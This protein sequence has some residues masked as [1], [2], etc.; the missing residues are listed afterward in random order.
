MSEENTQEVSRMS[1]TVSFHSSSP[2][3]KLSDKSE[4]NNSSEG[5]E[6]NNDEKNLNS[7]NLLDM[8][9]EE[10]Q[11]ESQ[12]MEKNKDNEKSTAVNNSET[13][14]CDI[15]ADEQSNSSLQVTPQSQLPP[16][17]NEE[18]QSSVATAVSEEQGIDLG[19]CYCGRERNLNTVEL[20]CAG[21][22]KWFH[23]SCIT[24][25]LGKCVPFMTNYTFLCKN[26]NVT[27]M[28]N[29]TKK[30]S[31]FSQMCA[32]A[33]A[34]LLQQNSPKTTFSKDKDIIPFIEKHW[35]H[36]TTMP[37]RIKQT[38]HT[39]VFKTMLKDSEIFL[40]EEKNPDDYSDDY[41][42]FGL[43]VNDLSKIGP[44]YE[45]LI[46]AGQVKQ[47][48]QD[49]AFNQSVG[50]ISGKGRS[51]KRKFPG[52]GQSASTGKKPRSDLTMPKLPPH[53]YPLEHPFNKDGY[54]YILAEPDPHAPFRQEF[55]ESPDW[56]G[57]PIPG[58]LYRKLTPNFVLWALHDRAPQLKIGED[59]I[60]VTGEK[61]YCMIRSTHGIHSGTWY[62][63]CT[64]EDMPDGSA[65]RLGWSQALG[66][67]QAPLGYDR[68][69]Y[70]WRSRKGTRFHQSMG[71]HYSNGGYGQG[72]TLGFLI[73]LPSIDDTV[74]L[75]QTYKDKPLVKFK[76]YL[77]FEDKDD[78]QSAIKGLKPLPG[79]KITFYKNGVNM[80]IAWQDISAG[81]YYPA[82]SLYK[83]CTVSANFG[84][85]FRYPPK[86][87]KF[88]AICE[89]AQ[90]AIIEQTLSDM[91]YLIEN[92]GKLR[93]DTF[94]M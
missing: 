53:G 15:I 54:R 82:L 21:C 44:N 50:F 89:A 31:N 87:T 92:E 17:I 4:K 73:H 88:R 39:T 78:I 29:F 30:Q 58:W 13:S 64:I 16:L 27:G 41:P 94:M 8:Y 61:G 28:E 52:D 80:G 49:F 45:S 11:Q 5:T 32:T 35:E 48:M 74:V 20:Q 33:I 72:D 75:P 91:L 12:N 85:R 22:L 77:Y 26:C 23:D 57:K 60:Y 56:A 84:P 66:N 93:L 46:R 62:F 83:S 90:D 79:S 10:S 70:S 76:S 67:L 1:E 69:S 19:N 2:T 71:Y 9:L 55:D 65:T 7:S 59:R 3:V 24:F 68:F 86:D 43:V 14:S 42:H 63:E 37:R 36:L 51:A 81:T 25:P 47:P 18:S 6:V 40:V 34:N 38:W